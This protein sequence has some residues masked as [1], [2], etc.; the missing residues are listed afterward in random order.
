MARPAAEEPT[1]LV[2]IR[3][4]ESLASRLERQ[5]KRESNGISATVRRL[6]TIGL[7]VEE[8]RS[9]EAAR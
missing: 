1:S 2:S 4:P 6:L 7:E 3:V 5:A 8:R 9:L